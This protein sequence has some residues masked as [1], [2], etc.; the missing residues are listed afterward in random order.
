MVQSILPKLISRHT[1]VSTL[2]KQCF[3]FQTT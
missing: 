1:G 2:I 3:N